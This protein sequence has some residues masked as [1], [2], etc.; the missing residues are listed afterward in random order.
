MIA[1]HKV[2]GFG[3]KREH[4]LGPQQVVLTIFF[5]CTE[6]MVSIDTIKQM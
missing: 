5:T 3:Q 1:S 4:R 2:I 6:A